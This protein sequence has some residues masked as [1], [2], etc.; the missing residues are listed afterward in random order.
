MKI[1]SLPTELVLLIAE[2]LDYLSAVRL[3][4]TS[5]RYKQ[6]LTKNLSYYWRN[7][8]FITEKTGAYGPDIKELIQSYERRFFLS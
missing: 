4:L 3:S 8:K 5:I 2:K 7:F 6:I 1:F